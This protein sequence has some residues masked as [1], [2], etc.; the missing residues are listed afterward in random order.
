MTLRVCVSSQQFSTYEITLS[1]LLVT[2]HNLSQFPFAAG[3]IH[4][5]Y[6]NTMAAA[7]LAFRVGRTSAVMAL[8]RLNGSLP[9]TRTDAYFISIILLL[10]LLLSLHHHYHHHHYHHYYYCFNWFYYHYH[11]HYYHIV[12][13]LSFCGVYIYVNELDNNCFM[14]LLVVWVTPQ[15]ARFMW[16]IWDPSGSWRPQVGPTLA[17]WVLL[18]WT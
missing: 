1:V 4:E 11:Y 7:A 12:I 6:F 17:P 9:F 10:L 2:R 8:A 3:P 18:S 16:S 15:I 13:N 5:K 14:Q